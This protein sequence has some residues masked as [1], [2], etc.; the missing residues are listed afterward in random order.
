MTSRVG[1]LAALVVGPLVILG[2]ISALT[3]HANAVGRASEGQQ[4]TWVVQ[5][6]SGLES[7]VVDT[8]H[9]IVKTDRRL[10]ALRAYLRAGAELSA[11]WTW[12]QERLS[13]FAESAEGKSV[14][15]DIDAVA[16]AFARANPGYTLEV[17]RVPRSLDLQ[18]LRWNEDA[19][20]GAS[21][22][23]LTTALARRFGGAGP[24]PPAEA[25][26]A[27]LIDWKPSST[28]SV[29]APGLSAHGQ[30]R[31]FDF[32]VAHEGQIIAGVEVSTAR[33]RWDAAGWT[34]RLHEAVE[35]A[36]HH[37]VGPLQSP[38]EPWHYS[39]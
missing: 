26:R 28:A 24:T 33:Q 38:Y 13:G 7:A 4:E 15:I 36:G 39:H 27:A 17:N 23:A 30:G 22:A 1:Y 29:A 20:V 35:A 6:S 10:L 12:S 31:A 34:R 16:A 9:R 25:V 11:R 5:G 19:S 2:V 21:A 37:F 8:L 32:Q 3:M 18:L 14:A